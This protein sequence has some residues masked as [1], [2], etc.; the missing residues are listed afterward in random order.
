MK[1][2]PTGIPG[3]DELIEGGFP[4]GSAVLLSGGTGTGKTIF[5]TQ[6]VYNGASR[7]NEPGIY[8]TVEEG[9]TNIWWNMQ[10]FGWDIAGLT[11]QGLMKIYKMNLTQ[12]TVESIEEEIGRIADMVEQMG[13][14]RLVIDSTTA[15]GVWLPDPAS[16][17]YTIYKLVSELKKLDCTSLLVA[18]TK[19]G[20]TDFSAFGVEEF[21][22]D[23]VI[24]LYFVPPHRALFV[25]KMRGTKHSVKVHPFNI[26]KTGIVVRPRDELLWEAIR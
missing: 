12:R 3:M 14:K 23:G 7:F 18:E 20:K 8:I 16:I 2:V 6:F 24:A 4:E 1:R 21:V 19:G 11:K 15:I 22:A 17:R 26:G 5:S 10:N 13:A 25:R 9:P